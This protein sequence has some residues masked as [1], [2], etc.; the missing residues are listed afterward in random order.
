M[1]STTTFLNLPAEIHFMICEYLDPASAVALKNATKRLRSAL[2]VKDPKYF[3]SKDFDI[4]YMKL[5]MWPEYAGYFF[6]FECW[7]FLPTNNFT[8]DQVTGKCGKN[9]YAA[10]RRFCMSCGANG[11]TYHPYDNNMM[12]DQM[13]YYYRHL[14]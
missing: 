2:I 7:V 3:K 5:E 14:Q 9:G 10:S 12:D 1:A 11:G 8:E 13:A 6:C 4:Y